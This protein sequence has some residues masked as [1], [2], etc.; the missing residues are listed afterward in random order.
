MEQDLDPAL[1]FEVLAAKLR[2]DH[3]A[4][5]DLLDLLAKMLEGSYPSGTKVARGGWFM[6]KQRP[7]EELSVRFDEWQFVIAREKHGTISAR[8]M[9]L[10]K[11]VSLKTNDIS[12]DECIE[13]IIK[14]IMKL[15]ERNA[16]TR[17]ALNRFVSG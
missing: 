12:M 13:Q 7:V 16:Q 14:E 3:G 10:V 2:G 6:S 5:E 17:E 1:Q 11:G 9:K 8:S 15:A 4:S